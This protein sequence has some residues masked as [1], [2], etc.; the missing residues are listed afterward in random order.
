MMLG[1]LESQALQLAEA[2]W[3]RLLTAAGEA[4]AAGPGMQRLLDGLSAACGV[5]CPTLHPTSQRHAE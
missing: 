5:P 4:L 1:L 2:D 3:I